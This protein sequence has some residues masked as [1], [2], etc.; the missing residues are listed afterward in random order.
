MKKLTIFTYGAAK[1]S[2]G[3][4]AVGVLVT[5]EKGDKV[6]DLVEGIGNA[7]SDYAQYFAVVRALQVVADRLGDKASKMEIELRLESDLV[8]GNLTAQLQIKNVGLIG[9]FI[10]IFNLRV[11]HFP[12]M[13]VIHIPESQNQEAHTLVETLLDA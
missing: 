2:P 3:A 8:F 10:E 5:D 4:A 13:K 12:T 11:A 7:T 1:S 9:H 6:I